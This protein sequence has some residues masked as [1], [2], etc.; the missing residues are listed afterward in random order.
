MATFA[1]Q[2]YL[3]Y[4][5][6]GGRFQT[7]KQILGIVTERLITILFSMIILRKRYL[8]GISQQENILYREMRVFELIGHTNIR[9][10]ALSSAAQITDL[11]WEISEG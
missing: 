11:E 5:L 1:G 8:W 2:C 10:L 4:R 7:D 3:L 6:W 9:S